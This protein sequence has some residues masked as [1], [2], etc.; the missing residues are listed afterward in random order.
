MPNITIIKDGCIVDSLYQ[1][2]T[3][4]VME[5]Y[6]LSLPMAPEIHFAR[7]GMREAIVCQ[8]TKDASGVIRV[9]VPDELL[10]KSGDLNAYVCVKEGKTFSTLRKIV[11]PVIARAE[12]DDEEEAESDG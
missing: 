6:G 5:I 12:P 9:T 8:S 7:F 2:D 10:E 1:W 4:Q 11:L 3:G